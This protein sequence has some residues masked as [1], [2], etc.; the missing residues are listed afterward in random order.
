MQ[1]YLVRHWNIHNKHLV[2]LW[3]KYLSF[4]TAKPTKA[5]IPWPKWASLSKSKKNYKAENWAWS[6]SKCGSVSETCFN[7]SRKYL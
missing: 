7:F 5:L 6:K 4:S 2:K 1:P 3:I